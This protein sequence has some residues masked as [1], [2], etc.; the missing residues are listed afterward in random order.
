MDSSLF[1]QWATLAAAWGLY[2]TLHSLL[3]SEGVK[4]AC[5]VRWPGVMPR[6]RLLYNSVAVVTLLPVAW[7]IFTTHGVPFL[8]WPEALFW[9]KVAVVSC[10]ALCFVWSLA[11]YD[12]K[13][14]MGFSQSQNSSTLSSTGTLVISPLHR[15]VRHPW[16]CCLLFIVWFR[17]LDSTQFFTAVMITIYLVIGSR[18]EEGR[19]LNE[20]GEKYGAYQKRVPGLMPLPWRY[21]TRND[22]LIAPGE[23][24]D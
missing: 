14:F 20:F 7:L 10:A 12:L 3:A 21:L 2:F 5:E 19:L 24:K 22:P 4:R 8:V 11:Y 6:Y 18:L 17:D 16:Y 23:D 13:A 9:L 15:F 1:I